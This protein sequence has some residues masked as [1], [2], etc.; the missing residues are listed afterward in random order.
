MNKIVAWIGLMRPHVWLLSTEEPYIR[1]N[2]YDHP[3]LFT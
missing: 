2:I 3:H 1:K